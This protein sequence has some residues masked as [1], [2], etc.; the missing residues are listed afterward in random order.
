M[1]KPRDSRPALPLALALALGLV[2]AIAGLAT[3]AP[4]A[5]WELPDNLSNLPG[6]SRM[7]TMARDP[8]S[9]DL[10][11]AWTE[12][13]V[14]AYDE[15]LGRR[16][17]QTTQSWLPG[18]S[19]PAENLSLSQWLDA[20]PLLVFD[21]QGNGLLIWTRRYATIWGAAADGTDLLWREWDGAAWSPEQVLTHSDSFLPGTYGLIPVETPGGI[22]LFITFGTGYR[23]TLFQNGIWSAISPW[24]YL[25]FP[26]Q[27]RPI[28]AHVIR[29]DD[30]LLHAA[31]YAKN[32][33]EIGWDSWFNDAYYLTYDGNNW[34]TPVNLSFTDGV[35]H[36]V[37]MSFDGQGRLHFLWSDPDSIYSSESLKSA[38]WERVLDGGAWTPN[39]EV[40]SYNPDQAID[41]FSLTG[42]ANGTLH[43]AWSEGLIV[44]WVHT[45]LDI[46]YQTGDGA[47]WRSE[48]KVYTSTADSRYP[49]LGAGADHTT[50]LWEEGPSDDRDIYISRRVVPSGPCQQVSQVQITG[51]DTGSTATS[52]IFTALAEPLTATTPLTYTWQASD[53]AA[54]VHSGGLVDMVAFTWASTGTKGITLTVENCGG[55]ATDTH[56]IILSPR[57]LS[58]IY[59]PLIL[60]S[61][62]P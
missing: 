4:P 17:Q 2:V 43:I 22:L 52:H 30:G 34:T 10:F 7:A 56:S 44:D 33:S 12:E 35:A 27:V 23:T 6:R 31:A 45:D 57:I 58:P 38:I 59:L 40:T 14:A 36:D 5:G 47:G 55:V 26:D 60:Q 48:E 51:P 20:G 53:L 62:T 15:I 3:A 11:V 18:L 39:T 21:Q 16:W 61:T 9:G 46:Y 54:E 1:K 49:V 50:I 24:T 41:T 19:L 29:D 13:G 32:S 25:E 37:G 42:D 8:G 28:L